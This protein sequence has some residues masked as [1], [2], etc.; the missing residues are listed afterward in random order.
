MRS[1]SCSGGTPIK[2][3]STNSF[4]A[5]AG[6]GLEEGRLLDAQEARSALNVFSWFGDS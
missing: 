4:I 1:I 3:L 5:Y 2:F 6:V